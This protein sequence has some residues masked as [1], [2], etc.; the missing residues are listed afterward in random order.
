MTSLMVTLMLVITS[1]IL[2]AP[3]AARADCLPW[4]SEETQGWEKWGEKAG[5]AGI[6]IFSKKGPNYDQFKGI[7]E[8]DASREALINLLHDPEDKAG[9]CQKLV[10]KCKKA[11]I[12]SRHCE[13]MK[14]A[15]QDKGESYQFMAFK[16]ELDSASI[17]SWVVKLLAKDRYVVLHRVLNEDEGKGAT[18]LRVEAVPDIC[19]EPKLRRMKAQSATWRFQSKEGRTCVSYE[20]YSDPDAPSIV[21]DTVNLEIGNAVFGTLKNMKCLRSENGEWKRIHCQSS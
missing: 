19:Q 12:V 8:I 6:T 4:F 1:I 5:E 11:R 20:S 15:S 18:V 3:S 21:R 10:P 2:I 13:E 7:M 17:P 16:G 14:E 9:E